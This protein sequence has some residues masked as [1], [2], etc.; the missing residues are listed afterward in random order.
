MSKFKALNSESQLLHQSL[1]S[2]NI[3][4]KSQEYFKEK[5][6]KPKMRFAT[7]MEKQ[8]CWRNR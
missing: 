3:F 1:N 4:K 2:E 8:S 7:E 6:V 5:S